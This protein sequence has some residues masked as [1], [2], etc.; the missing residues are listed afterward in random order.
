MRRWMFLALAACVSPGPARTTGETGDAVT[1]STGESSGTGATGDTSATGATGDTSATGATGDTSATG[2]T[3][4]TGATGASGPPAVS[5]PT[6]N[7][8]NFASIQAALNA[9]VAGETVIVPA[10]VYHENLVFPRGDI[11][12]Y[13]EPGAILDGTGKSD[14]GITITSKSNVRV[15]GMTV[16]AFTGNNTPIGISVSGGGSNIEVAYNV[17]SG[18]ESPNNNAHGIAFYGNSATPLSNVTVAYNEIKDC[19]LG[20]SEALVLNGNVDGF[21]V[22]HNVVHDTD[23]IAIDFI[24]FEGTAPGAFDQA[25]NGTCTDNVVYAVSSATNPTYGGERSADGIYVDGGKDI[26]IERNRVS[27]CDIGIEIASE[28]QGKTTSNV[29]VQN[30]FVAN[31]FQGNVM[32]GG[33][34]A[35]KGNATGITI[36]SNTLYH[37]GDGEIVLQYNVNGLTVASN[38]CVA[39]PGNGYVV[40]TGAGNAN[41]SL[42]GNLYSGA[43]SSSPGD[44]PDASAH[45]ANP[46]LVAP[47]ADLHLQSDSPAIDQGTAAGAFDVD[48]QMRVQGTAAD[49]GADEAK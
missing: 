47:P 17:I 6:I 32:V 19:K 44:F 12:L 46:K 4:A 23:N 29:T 26:V 36:R 18:I 39:Q 28:H 33:Y 8:T 40:E 13:G 35:N 24:G 15:I 5:G 9:A 22:A 21:S 3:S 30:N 11:A 48:G 31:S 34:A 45:Y 49:I 37:G 16:R 20:Q 25:R 27:D 42:S 7:V 43:S 38:V 14:V 1:G 41:V 10:G 2:S